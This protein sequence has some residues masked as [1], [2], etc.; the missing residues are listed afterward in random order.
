MLEDIARKAANK[1][2]SLERKFQ[3][4]VYSAFEVAAEW[5]IREGIKSSASYIRRNADYYFGPR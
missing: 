3:H 1:R 2:D 4:M 5:L